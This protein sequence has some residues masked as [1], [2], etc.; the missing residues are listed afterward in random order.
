MQFLSWIFKDYLTFETRE[1]GV[2]P[3]ILNKIES[4]FFN[5]IKFFFTPSESAPQK[6]RSTICIARAARLILVVC[7]PPFC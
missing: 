6:D 7:P 5:Y 2:A 3:V 4:Y 1:A